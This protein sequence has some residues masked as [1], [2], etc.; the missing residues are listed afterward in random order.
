MKRSYGGSGAYMRINREEFKERFLKLV[1][2]LQPVEID[3]LMSIMGSA[4][5]PK[6]KTLLTYGQESDTL[7][8]VWKGKLSILLES[9]DTILTLAEVIPGKWVG[10]TSIIDPGPVSATVRAVEDC[11]LFLLSHQDFKRFSQERPS[12]VA[13]MLRVFSKDLAATVRA[14][15]S[16]LIKYD[17][18]GKLVLET[19]PEHEGPGLVR[20]L[21]RLFGVSEG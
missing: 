21:A 14:S 12:A 13:A 6:G 2:E 17:S 5:L 16:G 4:Q 3:T 8:L 18:D 9:N 15:T 10:E 1:G 7:Y 11:T 19:S 20:L